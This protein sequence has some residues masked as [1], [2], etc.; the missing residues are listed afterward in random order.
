[1]KVWF[2]DSG[3][4]VYH[5]RYLHDLGNQLWRIRCFRRHLPAIAKRIY[6]GCLWLLALD[7]AAD[8]RQHW[9]SLRSASMTGNKFAL[10]EWLEFRCRNKRLGEHWVVPFYADSRRTSVVGT[11][12]PKF[13]RAAL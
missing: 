9:K 8:A 10:D 6:E 5:I 1:M 3:A 4:F 11:N 7:S 13:S 2:V 12:S